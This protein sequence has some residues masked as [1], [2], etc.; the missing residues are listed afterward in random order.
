MDQKNVD[1]LW[2]IGAPAGL[3]VMTTGLTMSKLSLRSGMYVY[4]YAEYPSLIKGGHNTYECCIS[5]RT[6]TTP[7]KNIDCLVC[8]N[9]ETATLHAHRLTDQSLVV[10]DPAQFSPTTP[11]IQIPVPM[12]ELMNELQADKVMLNMV[13]LGASCALL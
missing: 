11:G 2:K 4:D 13:A 10:F 9:A 1:F 3:G 5:T 7:K 6:V 8:F 12:Q